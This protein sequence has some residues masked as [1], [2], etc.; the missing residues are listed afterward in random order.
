[1]FVFPV[2]PLF[3]LRV[4][5]HLNHAPFPHPAHRTGRARFRHPALGLDAHAAG[6]GTPTGASRPTRGGFRLTSLS[7]PSARRRLVVNSGPFAPRELPRF[8]A[9]TSPSATPP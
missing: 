7:R 2:S 6:R 4:S 8:G 1:M 5:H 9:T 3:R